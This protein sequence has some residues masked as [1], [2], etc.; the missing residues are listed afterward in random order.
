MNTVFKTLLVITILTTVFSCKK[1]DGAE[2]LREVENV[3]PGQWE[4]ESFYIRKQSNSFVY[5]GD[6]IGGDTTVSINIGTLEFPTFSADSLDSQNGFDDNQGVSFSLE[7][8]DNSLFEYKMPNLWYNSNGIFVYFRDVNSVDKEG[9][10]SDFL[11]WANIFTVNG[12][13]TIEDS[14]H[15]TISS[16]SD[17]E[18]ILMKLVKK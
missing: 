16:D 6:T 4:F 7:G 15:I 18:K 12:Y 1:N 2:L 17:K 9:E 11:S 10:L 3:L 14:K 13:M 8:K 5:K